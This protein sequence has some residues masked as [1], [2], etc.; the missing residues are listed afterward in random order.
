MCWDEA[1][2]MGQKRKRKNNLKNNKNKGFMLDL[3]HRTVPATGK[4][5]NYPSWNK[6]TAEAQSD[7]C[8]GKRL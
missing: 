1:T 3:E 7:F 2:L 5:I 8:H 4:N 6:D